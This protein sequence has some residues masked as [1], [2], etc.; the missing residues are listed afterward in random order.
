MGIG[1]VVFL[2]LLALVQIWYLVVTFRLA[3]ALG[4]REMDIFVKGAVLVC[5]TLF[6]TLYF[7]YEE[8]FQ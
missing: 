2:V 1:F 7:L 5:F 8:L 4:T 6:G 3:C